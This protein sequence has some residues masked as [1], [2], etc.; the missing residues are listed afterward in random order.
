MQGCQSLPCSLYPGSRLPR[1][2]AQY[3]LR[4]AKSRLQQLQLCQAVCT[5][6]TQPDYSR[7]WYC[8]CLMQGCLQCVMHEALIWQSPTGNLGATMP[9]PSMYSL[10]M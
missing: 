1:L 5:S 2:L 6:F 7:A 9:L 10:P 4:F 3:H 8:R